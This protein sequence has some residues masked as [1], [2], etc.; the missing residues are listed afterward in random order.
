MLKNIDPLLSPDL[1]QVLAA[2]GHGDDLVVVDANFPADAVARQTVTGK[3]IRLDGVDVVQAIRAILSVYPLDSF[4]EA[5][6]QRMEIAGAPDEVPEVQQ[7]VQREIDDAEGQSLPMGS[8]ERFAFYEEAKKAYAVVAT[9]E[10][11]AYGCF[12]LKKGVIFF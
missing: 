8:I 6:A 10:G 5:P 4:V 1:L 12:L 7:E 9:T 11:R 2:M 3:L